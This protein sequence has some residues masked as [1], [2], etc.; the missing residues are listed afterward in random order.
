[1]KLYNNMRIIFLIFSFFIFES[2]EQA[3]IPRSPE[4]D[5][6]DEGKTDNTPQHDYNYTGYYKPT[7]LG[8]GDY[9]HEKNKI[10]FNVF[11]KKTVGFSNLKYL[12]FTIIIFYNKKLRGLE[13]NDNSQEIQVLGILDDAEKKKNYDSYKVE[14]DISK[15]E[16]K[17]IIKINPKNDFY[18]SDKED[19]E[20]SEDTIEINIP[21]GLKNVDLKEQTSPIKDKYIF[22]EVSDLNPT[23]RNTYELYGGTEPPTDIKNG[24]IDIFY[25]QNDYEELLKGTINKNKNEYIIEFTLKQSINT[26]L[27]GAYTDITHLINSNLRNLDTNNKILYLSEIE[28]HLLDINKDFS[29]GSQVHNIKSSSGLSGGVV[30]AIVIICVVVIIA[31]ILAIIFYKK[32]NKAGPGNSSAIEFYNS[33]SVINPN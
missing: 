4:D 25:F 3:T 24:D 6:S 32:Y 5:N 26:N 7:L 27:D 33:S 9:K 1:M 29:P 20:P 21:K 10:N 11:V 14:L 17:D 16:E 13:G 30:A 15:Y 18:I 28:Q 8:Y 19:D 2:A 22:F 23:K 12:H 31:C